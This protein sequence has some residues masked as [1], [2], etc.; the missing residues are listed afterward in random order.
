MAGGAIV[1][2]LQRAGYG[3]EAQGGA[4]LTAG[5]EVLDGAAVAAWFAAHQ[6]TV[7]VLAAAKV[8]ALRRTAAIRLISCST[9]S[10]SRTT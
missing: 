5:R 7:V 10:R 9:T 1:R 6:P 3:D 4:L 2:A 8:G